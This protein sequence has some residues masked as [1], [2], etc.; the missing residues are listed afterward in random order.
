VRALGAVEMATAVAALVMGGI[1]AVAVAVVYGALAI[2]AWRLLVRSPGTAC[3]CLGASDTPVTATHVVVNL[4][5]AIL[6]ALAA[7]NGS[8][9]TAVGSGVGSRLAFIVLVGCCA[10][11]VTSVLDAL[12]ALGA[13]VREGGSR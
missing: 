4:A 1:A 5:G 7:A 2:A 10:W 6:A 12:P 13:A 3:G 8:P 9:L 11:L